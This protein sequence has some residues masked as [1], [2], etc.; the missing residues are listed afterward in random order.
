MM[1][2]LGFWMSRSTQAA[3][4]IPET[5]TFSLFSSTVLPLTFGLLSFGDRDVPDRAETALV[6]ALICYVLVLLFA[7]VA[8]VSRGLEYRP[9]IPTLHEHGMNQSGDNLQAWVAKEY[10]ESTEANK[11]SLVR[12]ARLV[13]AANAFLFAEG[14]FLSLAALWTLL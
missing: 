13:G 14:I 6:G 1:P 10:L 8:S 4:W 12:K 11:A 7:W 2:L 5:R 9:H 3:S